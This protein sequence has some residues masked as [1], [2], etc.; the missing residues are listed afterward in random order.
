MWL[1]RKTT[2]VHLSEMPWKSTM[3]LC[4]VIMLTIVG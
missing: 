1:R 2:N 4:L 3:C